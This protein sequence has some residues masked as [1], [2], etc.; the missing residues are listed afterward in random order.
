M[1]NIRVFGAGESPLVNCSRSTAGVE[2]LVAAR[3]SRKELHNSRAVTKRGLEAAAAE[4][5]SRASGV[6]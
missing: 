6:M 1:K 4:M 5:L 3:R 2:K